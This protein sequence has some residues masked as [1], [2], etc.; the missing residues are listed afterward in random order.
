MPNNMD[1]DSNQMYYSMMGLLKEEDLQGLYRNSGEWT[2]FQDMRKV[3][4]H[5]KMDKLS[6]QDGCAIPDIYG[7]AIQTGIILKETDGT[8]E[9]YS[10][11]REIVTW[12]GI[13]TIIALQDYL[14]LPLVLDTI[15]YQGDNNAF[16]QALKQPMNIGMFD[17]AVGWCDGIFY[18]LTL[19]D[20]SGNGD[21]AFFS[22]MTLVCPVANLPKEVL[23]SARIRWFDGEAFQNPIQ[24]LDDTEKMI[25]LFWLK[26]I[27]CTV[28]AWESKEDIQQKEWKNKILS[29]IERYINDLNAEMRGQ[30]VDEK[31]C[32]FLKN[33]QES[34]QNDLV[35]S[36][37]N[38]TVKIEF[39]IGKNKPIYYKDIFS[40]KICYAIGAKG[41]FSGCAFADKYEIKNSNGLYT[42]IPISQNVQEELDRDAIEQLVKCFEMEILNKPSSNGKNYFLAK[43]ALTEISPKFIDIER[44][45]KKKEK[46]KENEC[47]QEE[48]P[49]VAMWPPSE[50]DEY[51]KRFIYLEGGLKITIANGQ[52]GSNKYVRGFD[53]MPKTISMARIVE[54]QLFDVGM[55]LPKKPKSRISNAVEKSAIVGIDFGTSKTVVSV[56]IKDEKC[57]VI[58]KLKDTSELLIIPREYGSKDKSSFLATM[59]DYFI[60]CAV[61]DKALYSIF[62]RPTIDMLKD[63]VPV[64]DGII[65]R[66]GKDEQIEIDDFD[67]FM[68]NIKWNG[69]DG[70]AYYIAFI[71]ELCMHIW[72]ELQKQ[73][74]YSVE[75]RYA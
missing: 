42:F 22:P 24:F 34:L 59:Q 75:W 37:L 3:L 23:K 47:I 17:R 32:F 40:Q 52:R 13:L 60:P 30:N 1:L 2:E 33:I 25:V 68:P 66:A 49:V 45:Y 58:D 50:I 31:K 48:L 35:D 5:M 54:D 38:Q 10:Y 36:I 65:Y 64:I 74:V 72:F 19:G 41:C 43:F 26:K 7:R 73:G 16:D 14:D 20:Q 8:A 6:F 63:V 12:R 57:Y 46:E 55:I 67:L 51:G 29:H 71:E 4:K 61:D 56:K 44:K 62:R 39:K 70:G 53:T 9:V 21:L 11:N 28:R 18:M 15:K 27:Q 69:A